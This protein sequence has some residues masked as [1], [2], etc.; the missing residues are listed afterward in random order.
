MEKM[1]DARGFV[2]KELDDEAGAGFITLDGV[3]YARQHAVTYALIPTAPG[4]Y[5]IEG[6]TCIVTMQ[7]R[8]SFFPFPRQSRLFFESKSVEVVAVPVAGAPA[9]YTGV[10]GEFTLTAECAP[11]PVPLYGE[12]AVTV[13]VAGRGN[14]MTL[15]KPEVSGTRGRV[16][17]ISEEGRAE[18]RAASSGL[19]G[20]KTF[21]FT[22]I[23][24]EAGDIVLGE[25]SLSYFNPRTERYETA[26]S[27]A[28]TITAAGEEKAANRMDFDQEGPGI[29]MNPWLIALAGLVLAGV[30]ALVVLWERR[31]YALVKGDAV[32]RSA[33]TDRG[34]EPDMSALRSELFRAMKAGDGAAFVRAAER[35]M[36]GI[37]GDRDAAEAIRAC[38][39]RIYSARFGGGSLSPGDMDEIHT[40]LAGLIR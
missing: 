20:E 13:R 18:V 11:G 35:L 39:E 37:E 24:E 30:A 36:K 16:K 29:E 10:V 33:E 9:G 21:T 28:V 31:R 38:R 32:A 25:F 34:Q 8:D 1:P 2:I 15:G 7:R 5:S 40:L 17:I 3:E 26:R 27:G 12:K 23:P 6:G 14:L 22:A 19:E 4:W